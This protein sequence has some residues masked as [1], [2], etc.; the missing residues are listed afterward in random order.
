[1]ASK[2]HFFVFP[3]YIDFDKISFRK[4]PEVFEKIINPLLTDSKKDF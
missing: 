2:L 1:M 4:K 3:K